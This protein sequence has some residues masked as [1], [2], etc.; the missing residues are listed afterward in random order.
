MRKYLFVLAV[1]ILFFRCGKK[2]SP[3]ETAKDTYKVTYSEV[4]PFISNL[5]IN[6]DNKS[7]FTIEFDIDLSKDSIYSKPIISTAIVF[8]YYDKA[9]NKYLWVPRE[10]NSQKLINGHNIFVINYS[11]PDFDYTNQNY[12]LWNQIKY[13]DPGVTIETGTNLVKFS[14]RLQ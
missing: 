5:K 6:L 2:D 12:V 11:D 13:K 1:M 8:Q 3:V 4:N 14:V 9:Q 7:Y 10:E